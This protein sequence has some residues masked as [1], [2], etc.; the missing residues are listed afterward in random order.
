MLRG[1]SEPQVDYLADPR[2]AKV[3]FTQLK[4]YLADKGVDERTLFMSSTK[5]ALIATAEKLQIGLE[6]LLD[7]VTRKKKP[8]APAA[9]ATPAAPAAA[10]TKAVAGVRAIVSLSGKVLPDETVCA[11]VSIMCMKA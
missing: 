2:V 4:K 8:A 3:T 11:V 9:P 6:P 7:E 5:F 1:F 10:G